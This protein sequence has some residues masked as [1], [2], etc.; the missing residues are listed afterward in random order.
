MSLDDFL[1]TE[2]P[3][4]QLPLD[5]RCQI[6]LDNMLSI[7]K[8]IGIPIADGKTQGPSQALEFMGILLDT[9][10]MQA[11]SL[12]TKLKN[13]RATPCKNRISSFIRRKPNWLKISHINRQGEILVL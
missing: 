12:Q 3:A 13:L 5:S 9:S 8:I 11:S 7:S 6:S 10:K 4:T 1:I 2:P